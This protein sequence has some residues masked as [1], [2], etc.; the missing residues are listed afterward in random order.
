[1]PEDFTDLWDGVYLDSSLTLDSPLTITAATAANPVEITSVTHGL[2][3]GDQIRID[4]VEGM[5]ELNGEEFLIKSVAPDTFELTDLDGNDID[6]LLYTAYISG[7]EVR[8]MVTNISGLS[9]LEGETVQVQMD[10]DVPTINS[11]VVSGG[12]ITLASKAAVVHAGLP[13]TPL[14]KTLRPEGGSQIGTGQAKVKRI[15]NITVRF[16]KT[17]A[18]QL[19]GVDTQDRFEFTEIYTGDKKIPVPAGWD[20]AGQ[21][22]ITSDKPLPLT[23]IALCPNLNVSDL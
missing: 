18:C 13:Y 12:S 6:G 20:N 17:L 2:S 3:D 16:Y 19:G 4:G 15:P 5:T 10:G 9:H 7:G 1:M 22:I 8:E 21:L 11:F 23:V 14:M